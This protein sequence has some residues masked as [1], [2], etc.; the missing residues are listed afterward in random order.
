MS[1]SLPSKAWLSAWVKAREALA[2]YCH[3]EDP[4]HLGAF[5]KHVKVMHDLD[6]SQ[7]LEDV[8]RMVD[9]IRPEW[10]PTNPVRPEILKR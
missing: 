2:I 9:E 3:T 4:A 6:A 5:N 1:N 7:T 8:R 10:D